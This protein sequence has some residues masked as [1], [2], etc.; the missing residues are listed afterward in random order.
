[1]LIASV[2]LYLVVTIAMC[3]FA[4]LLSIVVHDQVDFA[5]EALAPF[6]DLH[7][8]GAE[9]TSLQVRAAVRSL[10]LEENEVTQLLSE[11][12]AAIVLSCQRAKGESWRFVRTC[13]VSGRAVR[14]RSQRAHFISGGA[15]GVG[16]G[17][18]QGS[19]SKSLR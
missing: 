9:L 1:M 7:D 13:M 10:V 18:G 16:G 14:R 12:H 5:T 2:A 11:T 3:S 17:S 6:A 15:R 19:W 4:A 8:A